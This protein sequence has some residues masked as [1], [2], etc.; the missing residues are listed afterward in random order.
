[1]LLRLNSIQEIGRFASLIHKGPQF[2]RLTLIYARN[3]YGKSTLTSVLRS[4]SETKADYILARRRLGASNVSS[5][6]FEW[7]SHGSISFTAGKWDTCPG[8]LYIFDSDYVQQNLHV[9]DSVT[10]DNKRSLLR[11]VLGAKGV[12]LARTISEIDVEQKELTSKLAALEKTIKA[13][14]NNSIGDVLSFCATPTPANI[15]EQVSKAKQKVELGVR[16]ITVQQ[17]KN[18]SLIHL[19]PFAEFETL[20]SRSIQDISERASIRI[21]EHIDKHQMHPNGMR[22]LRYGVEHMNGT[23]CPFCTQ[24]AG[25]VDLVG[26]FKNYFNTEFSQLETELSDAFLEIQKLTEQD[27]QTIEYILNH[28]AS[29]FDFWKSVCEFDAPHLSIEQIS[30]LANGL[31]SL[32]AILEQKIT[33]PHA[34]LSFGAKRGEILAAFEI[35]S[36]YNDKIAQC[37]KILEVARKNTD[38]IDLTKAK[39]ELSYKE[40]LRAKGIDPLKAD[41]QSYL[42]LIEHQK[43]IVKNKKIAQEELRKY[44]ETVTREKQE[45]INQILESFGANFSITDTKASYVGREPNTDFSILIGAHKIQAGEINDQAPCF[46]TVLSTSDKFTL[47]LALFISQVR[48]DEN[49]DDAT[50]VFDDPFSSQDMYRQWATASQI[51]ELSRDAC[52]VIVLSHDPRFLRQITKEFKDSEDC[53]EFKLTCD[54]EGLGSI[55]QWSSEDEL[56]SLY[57]QQAE[58][59]W[60]YANKGIFLKGTNADNLTK[61]LR[62]FLEDYLRARFPGRFGESSYLPAMAENIENA[63][64]DDPMFNYV[65]AIKQINEFTRGNMHGGAEAP[66]PEALRVQCKQIVRIVGLY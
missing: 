34:S 58:R 2:P 13:A 47:A 24:D 41:I 21:Q 51:R 25:H 23:I 45:E 27:A 36:I 20:I 18:P 4:A 44:T 9:G 60:E 52:Q 61:D 6:K 57:V 65:K 62:P 53:K 15:N 22:W 10:R 35:A 30:F 5:V 64:I 16:S 39:Q 63:G 19:R 66:N 8:R 1:M 38:G 54:D 50:I 17:K 11:V 42:S 40:S 33:A 43:Q 31:L 55:S 56:K 59:I 37:I 28:N 29:D 14:C 49:L 32:R 48:S 12:D 7:K 46:K 3:G 26:M